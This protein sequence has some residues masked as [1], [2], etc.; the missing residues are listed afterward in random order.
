MGCD[1]KLTMEHNYPQELRQLREYANR[2]RIDLSD[3]LGSGVD[4]LVY[5]T[6][7]GSAVKGHRSK[8]TF[9]KELRAFEVL[10]KYPDQDFAGFNVPRMLDFHPELMVIEMQLVIP[11]FVVDFTG[12]TIGKQSTTF[13]DMS[14]EDYEEWERGKIEDYGQSDWQVVKT[15]IGRFRRIGIFLNDIHKGNIRI[16]NE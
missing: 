12:A 10:S 13:S 2:K 8:Q 14:A 11:P 9:Q 1:G 4:G 6:T 15:V 3:R 5:S 7:Q 16:S